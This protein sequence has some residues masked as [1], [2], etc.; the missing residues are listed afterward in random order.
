LEI[1]ENIFL[2][3]VSNEYCDAEA[4]TSITVNDLFVPSVIT[5]NG[6]GLNDFFKIAENIGIVELIIINRWGNE[7]YRNR[8][9][10]NDWDGLNNRGDKLPNDTYFYILIFENGTVKKGSVLIKK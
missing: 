1:G 10:L 2:W 3:K 5:P 4:E 7:E 8:N 9:Y 6:D